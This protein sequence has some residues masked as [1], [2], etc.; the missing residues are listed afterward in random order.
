MPA[1]ACTS[2]AAAPYFP[3]HH[4]IYWVGLGPSALIAA[5]YYRFVTMCHYKEANPG[6]DAETPPYEAQS[7]LLALEAVY[8][9]TVQ[10]YKIGTV[11]LGL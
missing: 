3:G 4:W 8:L 10:Q 2:R 11:R 7:K 5:G 1:P 9:L 6:Q